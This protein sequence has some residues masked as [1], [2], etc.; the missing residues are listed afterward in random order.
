MSAKAP[1]FLEGPEKLRAYYVRIAARSPQDPQWAHGIEVCDRW[2][3]LQQRQ[4]LTQADI[5]SVLQ[6]L[7]SQARPGSGWYIMRDQFTAWATEK[8][9]VT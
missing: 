5:D 8:G 2:L 1:E 7:R 9:F 6:E 4:D 3:S